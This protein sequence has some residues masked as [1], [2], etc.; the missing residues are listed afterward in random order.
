MNSA[1][2]NID[3]AAAIKVPILWGVLILTA[4]L[5]AAVAG[6][7][8]D[9][10]AFQPK[11]LSRAGIYALRQIDPNLTGEG[12]R[13]GIICRSVTYRDGEPQND[14]R[15]NSNHA[16]FQGAKL[17]FL[18]D[19]I[20]PAGVSPHAN[21]I[22]SI[23]FGE[24][25]QAASAE[26]GSF[27]YQGA[28]PGAEGYIFE[29]W[30]FL[31]QYV[32]AQA[33]V[34]VD[35]MAA[36]IGS[37]FEDWWTRGIESMAEHEGLPVVA[38]IG[39]GS[40]VSDPPLYPG[41]GSNVIG[42]G[43]VSSVKTANPATNLTYFALAYP[44]CSSLGPTGDGRCK[45]DLI[46]PGNCLVAAATDDRTYD[47]CGDW[48]SY[49]TPVTAGVVGLLVQAA[50]L[51]NRLAAILSAQGGNCALKAIL[52]T[53]ATKLPYWHK[54]RLTTDDD[55][56]VPLDYIQGAGMVDAVASYRL[57][58]VGQVA[59]DDVRPTGW[60][61]NRISPVDGVQHAYRI[62]VDDPTDQMLTATLTWNRHYRKEYPFDRIAESDTNLRLELWAVDPTDPSNNL[63]LD[64]SDSATDNVE[65][66]YVQMP[67]GYSS[68]ELVVSF[69]DAEA[70]MVSQASELY[71]V[72]WRIGPK[73]DTDSIFL[74]DLNADGIVDEADFRI[75]LSNRNI[76]MAS[77]DA[78][79]LGDINTD[80]VIDGKDL[81][82]LLAKRDRKADWYSASATN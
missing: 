63:L 14:Y 4:F 17:R 56:E 26:L 27:A 52:M 47:A 15:P 58:R 10:L 30:H 74:Y 51:D 3:R 46:A 76:G 43:V 68:Y 55:H 77:P 13:L 72:A 69:S 18:D 66:I 50:K 79:V 45:P 24:D 23:L 11:G 20:S 44:E 8:Q 32:F 9:G 38:S 28:V 81:T 36:S 1:V 82:D 78:Y 65:H 70:R 2:R 73:Q 54:G 34:G 60:D 61:L 49:S 7:S 37:P 42:V 25:A 22:C 39:N 75:F 62:F 53:A 19:G 59:A 64:Y 12:I 6:Q 71:G 35:V 41:A 31:R 5:A 80:G 21:A 33:P 57:L 48:S 67:L 40:N 29:F 16:C